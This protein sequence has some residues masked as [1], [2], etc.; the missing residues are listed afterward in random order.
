MSVEIALVVVA[1]LVFIVFRVRAS[2]FFDDIFERRGTLGPLAHV[3][4]ASKVLSAIVSASALTLGVCLAFPVPSTD[5]HDSGIGKWADVLRRC[6]SLAED[7]RQS[8]NHQDDPQHFMPRKQ[9]VF[10]S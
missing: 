1:H 7:A 2:S 9:N 5:A 4:T 3:G 6:R 8:P 10:H